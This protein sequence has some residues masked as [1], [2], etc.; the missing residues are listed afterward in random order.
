[1]DFKY[2]LIVSGPLLKEATKAVISAILFHRLL[3]SNMPQ[4][5]E[6]YGVP[7]STN[8]LSE[9]EGDPT[10]A[11]PCVSDPHVDALVEEAASRV[12]KV[13]ASEAARRNSTAGDGGGGGGAL[14]RVLGTV[15]VRFLKSPVVAGTVAGHISYDEDPNDDS[16]TWEIWSVQCH[17]K[18][19]GSLITTI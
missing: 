18:F 19:S 12:V 16:D 11:Y 17:G 2:D 1:M 10:V 6:I 9:L 8:D 15:Q 3:G 7:S 4:T 13:V 5:R 14:S